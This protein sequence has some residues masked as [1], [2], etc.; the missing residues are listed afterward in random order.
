[1]KLIYA[2]AALIIATG[3]A[4]GFVT[5][6]AASR[7]DAQNATGADPQGPRDSLPRDRAYGGGGRGSGG[8]IAGT[9]SALGGGDE[10]PD[11]FYLRIAYNNAKKSGTGAAEKKQALGAGCWMPSS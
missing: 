11:C 7:N 8:G 2:A 6:P 1:M 10:R 4:I 3:A 5:A 9:I